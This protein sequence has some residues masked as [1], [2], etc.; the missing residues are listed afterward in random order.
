MREIVPTGEQSEQE[1]VWFSEVEL[2][3][4]RL[5]LDPGTSEGEV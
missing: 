3:L 1:K 2:K 5:S 4:L